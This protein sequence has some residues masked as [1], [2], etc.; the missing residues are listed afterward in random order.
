[1]CKGPETGESGACLIFCRG[2]R[3]T[4]AEQAGDWKERGADV[5]SVRWSVISSVNMLL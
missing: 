4:G 2:A 1:M 3:V 5:D